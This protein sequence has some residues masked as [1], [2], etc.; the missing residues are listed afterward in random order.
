[1]TDVAEKLAILKSG[2]TTDSRAEI[3]KH[4]RKARKELAI[5]DIVAP[6]R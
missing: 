4:Q 1:V 6:G 3:L 5:R 2:G